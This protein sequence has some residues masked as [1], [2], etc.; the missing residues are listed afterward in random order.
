MLRDY[1]DGLTI[2]KELLQNAD[3]AEATELNICYDARTHTR[4]ASKLFF[5]GMVSC[6]GPALVVHNNKPFTK[7]DFEN[8]T[9]LGGAT[10]RNE[11]LKIGKFGVGFNSVYHITDIPS[12]VSCDMLYVFD[13]TL[14]YLEKEIQDPARPGKKVKTSSWVIVHSKQLDPYTG[15]F[16]Y[17]AG[18]PYQGTIFRFPFRTHHSELSSTFYS[19]KT[20]NE[21]RQTIRKAGS[22]ILLFLQ[23]IKYITFQQIRQGEGSPTCLLKITKSD[24][25][26]PSSSARMVKV[27]CRSFHPVQSTSEECWLLVDTHDDNKGKYSTA[28]VACLLE[29]SISQYIPR[30]VEGEIFCYLPLSLKTGLP[31]HV[32]SNFAVMSNRTGI[33]SSDEAT[34]KTDHEVQ[35]NTKLMSSVIPDAYYKLLMTLQLLHSKK[36]LQDYVFHSLWPLESKL[37]IHNPWCVAVDSLYNKIQASNLFYSDTTRQ[38]LKIAKGILLSRQI[39]NRSSTELSVPKCVRAIVQHLQLPIVDLPC[40]YHHHLMLGHS[41]LNEQ[42]FVNLFFKHIASLSNIQKSRNEVLVC[43]FE[44]HAIEYDKQSGRALSLIHI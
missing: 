37:H 9:K 38:W 11:P 12:F 28:S 5:E 32:S 27:T 41:L 17:E 16:G 3:D 6:H 8:I 34:T 39:L 24:T 35:W 25:K 33:W 20:I 14:K 1:K 40:E 15:L 23:N 29:G 43:M 10:K 30:K 7:S 18:K 26:L 44:I 19:E 21:L 42:R 13:P 22:K 36:M 2:I 31:V 4:D